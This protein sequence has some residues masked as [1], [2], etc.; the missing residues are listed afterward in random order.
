MAHRHATLRKKT[1]SA[2]PVIVAS[3]SCFM[4]IPFD[5]ANAQLHSGFVH[6]GF[7]DT[8]NLP[9][10][11]QGNPPVLADSI[12]ADAPVLPRFAKAHIAST[13]IRSQYG[14]Q[15]A[16][17]VH[18]YQG[19]IP[20]LATEAIL[21]NQP[22]VQPNDF[23]TLRREDGRRAA[24]VGLMKPPEK[25]TR[26]NEKP[27]A[28]SSKPLAADTQGKSDLRD[29]Q[30]KPRSSEADRRGPPSPR[31]SQP[32][33][34]PS[35]AFG[36]PFPLPPGP[37]TQIPGPFPNNWTNSG[38]PWLPSPH[39]LPRV[40]HHTVGPQAPHTNPPSTNR[41]T[42]SIE[43][44]LNSPIMKQL[45]QLKEE[46]AELRAELRIRELEFNHRL[47][48]M[49]MRMQMLKE[50]AAHSEHEHHSHA[51]RADAEFRSNERIVT[52]QVV[53]RERAQ[54][55][56]ARIAPAVEV[57]GRRD[58]RQKLSA[59]A[60]KPSRQRAE[61]KRQREQPPTE[62]KQQPNSPNAKPKPRVK[63]KDPA[64]EKE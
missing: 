17:S 20:S 31:G 9:S 36:P 46:N 8:A 62:L 23:S 33:P 64:S 29:D 1:L 13:I 22:P 34:K 54:A 56:E 48:Q 4:G 19:N 2:I 32:R 5:N 37:H 38:A 57:E 41:E 50:R 11:Y 39:L 55:R 28:E 35:N 52:P 24:E 40:P 42:E 45:L 60:E 15:Q 27:T 58:E 26:T 10:Q 18:N 21:T 14:Q 30:T 51:S 25:D 53:E 43:R 63:I 49:E 44:V 6:N 47:E 3:L 16:L 61:M 59:E 12:A 7:A